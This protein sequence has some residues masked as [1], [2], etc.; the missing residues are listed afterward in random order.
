MRRFAA[1][2]LLPAEGTDIDL[3]PIDVLSERA[4]GR[5][6][7]AEARAVGGYPVTA[8]DADTAGRSVPGEHDVARPVDPIERANLAII[9]GADFGIELQL[10]GD[11]RDP[12]GAEAL[13][14]QHRH[15]AGAEQ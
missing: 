14:S 10:L 15:G 11:V 3:R 5:I 6:A 2:G 9:G 4:R 8:R 1:K 12:A 13:P 7:D